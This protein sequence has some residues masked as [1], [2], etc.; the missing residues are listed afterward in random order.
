MRAAALGA[1]VAVVIAVVAV[2]TMTGGPAASHAA[3]PEVAATATVTRTDLTQT[4][5]VD[6]TV[7][8][9]GATT[10]VEAP[11][12]ATG[13]V[14]QAQQAV[15]AAEANLAADGQAQSDTSASDAQ[16]VTMAQ[17][18]QAVA[19]ASL[20]SDTV[21]LGNDEAA[22]TAMAAKEQADCAGDASASAGGPGGSGAS[23][24][25][26]CSADAAQ[27]ASDQQKVTGDQQKVAGD[28]AAVQ[29]DAGQVT[30]ARE[31]GAQSADQSQ[32]KLAQDRLSLANAQ[33]ALATATA[34]ATA[35][36]QA[37]RYTALPVVGQVVRPGQPLWSV[38]GVPVVLLSGSLTPWRAFAPGMPPGRDVAALDAAL[39]ALGDGNGLT[40]STTFTAA[41]AAAIT[42]LQASLGAPR[43]GA[44]PL[45][46]VVF[47]PTAVRVTTVHPQVGA[48][49]NGG[50]PVLDATSTTPLV[51]V[52]LPVSQTYLVKV[53]DPVTVTLPDNTTADGTITSVGTV[54]TAAS[55]SGS[56]NGN[57]NPSATVNL[58]VS[59]HR[60][61]PAAGLDQAPVTVNITNA[62]AHAVLAVP[63]TA[64]LALA[65]GGYAVEVVDTTGTHHLVGVT[66]GIF[67]DQAGTVEVR[68][69]GL[70]AGQAVV[71]AA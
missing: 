55:N 48:P 47:E 62:S 52:A 29:A 49:V 67:D 38:D 68:G 36:A 44:L 13:A 24:A 10:I 14:A 4:T 27:V 7:G 28:Q 53:G 40:P 42:R 57:S 33:A 41:T 26:P 23:A 6:G 17:Q 64:L 63:V 59:L 69:A 37:S 45:G 56:N 34:S 18:A 58:T 43:T 39:I 1:T 50:A 12:T 3:A 61:S 66:T 65:G 9:A 30:S 60:A 5:P 22:L 71:V 35:Y 15:S 51:N 21:Q 31:R 8:Y 19:E 16:S 11:G 2:V 46:S 54:A 20:A 25:S 70:T 32:A